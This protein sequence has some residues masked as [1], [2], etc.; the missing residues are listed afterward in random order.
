MIKNK[1]VKCPLNYTGNKYKLL[2]Q[3]LPLF[4]QKIDTFLDACG[5]SFTVG[6]NVNA[7]KVI[8]NEI[9]TKIFELIKTLID[10]DID[11]FNSDV[12]KIIDTYGLSK[13]NKETYYPFRDNIY[14]ENQSPLLLFVLSCYSFNYNIRFNK[15]GKFNMPCGN[16]DYSINMKNNLFDFHNAT[17]DKVIEFSNSD[18][19]KLN[20]D[21]NCFVYIDPPYLPTI[22]SYTENNL[23]NPDKEN[24]MYEWLDSLNEKGVKFALSNVM[25]YRGEQN[26]LLHNFAQKYKVHNLNYKYT[27]NNCYQKDNTLETQEVLITNY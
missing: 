22:T 3:I 5:G 26:N 25:I 6:L 2:D 17:K 7:E 27:N 10:S 24:Q 15:S 16:R 9:D 19:T 8:Y 21:K 12:E 20:P 1:Y 18:F 4:P 14:N 11:K 23:W 13:N